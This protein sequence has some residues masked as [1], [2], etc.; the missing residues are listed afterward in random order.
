DYHSDNWFGRVSS[1]IR[2]TDLI[3]LFTRLMHW[4]LNILHNL[5][6]WIPGSYG[7]SIII[8]T[9]IVRGVMF[10]I[11]RK[12]ALFSIKMQELAPELKKLQ[13]KYP[14]DPAAKM[15]A[16]QEFYRKHGINPLGSCWPVFLQMPIF[17]GLYFA[18]QESIHFRLAEF[19]WIKNLA[20]PDMLIYWT[21]S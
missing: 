5:I 9:V 7:I 11:S 16:Q 21:E 1:F 19:A 20:A 3:I 2:L 17:L 14:D 8:L 15:Q 18:L 10:P 13:E 6:F 12:Q 4:L